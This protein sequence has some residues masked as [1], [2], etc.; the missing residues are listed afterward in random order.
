[1]HT[2]GSAIIKL[3]NQ[4]AL[5]SPDADALVST[6]NSHKHTLENTRTGPVKKSAHIV[7]LQAFRARAPIF[8]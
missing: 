3:L 4:R 1:M 2:A 5:C 8:G 6:T 7:E